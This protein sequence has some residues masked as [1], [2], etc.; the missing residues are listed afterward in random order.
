MSE[1][2]R[3]L[4]PRWTPLRPHRTQLDL[5]RGD[6]PR[7]RVCPAGRRSGKTERAKRFLVRQALASWRIPNARFAAAAPTRDQAKKIWWNDLKGLCP[8]H[9]LATKPSESELKLTFVTGATLEVLG[10]D[11]PER[12][13]GSPLDGIVLDEYGNMRG[14]AWHENV[15]PALSTVGRPGWAWFIGV[16]EGRNHYWDLYQRALVPGKDAWGV[17]RWPSS[18]IIDPAEVEA[19]REDLDELTFRQ[20]YLGEFLTFSGQAYYNFDRDVHAAEELSY[21]PT[22]PL[23]FC[24]DF[25]VEP[26]TAVVLQ[27][28][29]YARERKNVA[30][31]V[32]AVIGEVYIPRNS[33]TEAVC[34]KLLSVWGGHDGQV[35]IYGDAT[36]GARRTSALQG[37][38]WDIVRRMLRRQ[39]HER[40]HDFVARTNPPERSRVNAVNARLRNLDGE[41]RLLVCPVR[42]PHV[43]KDFEG[44]AL[45]EGGSG[46]IDKKAD[47]TLTHLTDALGYYVAERFPLIV[48]QA[49]TVGF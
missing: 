39:Y 34:R 22:K 6:G 49:A 18:D 31:W 24:F 2:A 12:V 14:S 33:N 28:Q 7:F 13:E 48:H 40:L 44:V 17:Y 35:H 27:H 5:I 47:R 3:I 32:T 41:V 21:D 25:N 1:P 38:D 16:P 10:M 36:G 26:G 8:P 4:T 45:L 37:S 20:E 42:A 29:R 23:V 46:E 30:Q 43:V 15:R 11:R 9:L 19:A